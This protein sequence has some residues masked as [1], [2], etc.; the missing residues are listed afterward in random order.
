MLAAQAQIAELETQAQ[1]AK[2]LAAELRQ[3]AARLAHQNVLIKQ[4]AAAARNLQNQAQ[5]ILNA[6]QE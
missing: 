4:G 2:V 6:P 5:Q 1:L 3:E